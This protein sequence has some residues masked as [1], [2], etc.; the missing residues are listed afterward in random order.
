MRLSFEENNLNC[1][2]LSWFDKWGICI[3]NLC[4]MGKNGNYLIP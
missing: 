4:S 1:M 3:N 2:W